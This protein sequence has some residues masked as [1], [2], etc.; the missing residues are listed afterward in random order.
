MRA[1]KCFE[2]C[3]I[4]IWREKGRMAARIPVEDMWL[5]PSDATEQLEHSN[6][7]SQLHGG[8]TERL[9]HQG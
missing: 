9:R 7:T 6:L 8:A 1:R 3:Q 5:E 2:N 4:L